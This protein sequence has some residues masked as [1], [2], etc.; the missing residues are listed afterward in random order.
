MLPL[1]VNGYHGGEGVICDPPAIEP[2]VKQ[3]VNLSPGT[4]RSR[5]CGRRAVPVS[6]QALIGCRH[7]RGAVR[8]SKWRHELPGPPE[9]STLIRTLYRTLY[10]TFRKPLFAINELGNRHGCSICGWTGFFFAPFGNTAR[11]LGS[12]PRCGS[13]ERHRLFHRLVAGSLGENLTV[14][15]VAPEKMV[16][17]LLKP[18]IGE[19]LSIDLM[20]PAMR[21]M[22]LTALDLPDA[23]FDLIF[24][25]HVLE[26]IPED[27]RAIAEM[28]RVLK[29]GGTAL[30][31]VPIRGESTYED[32]T[33]VSEEART[34][35]FLQPDHV[36]I[37]GLDIIERL[38]EP[39]FD[40]KVRSIREIDEKDVRREKLGYMFANEIFV[41]GR[42]PMAGDAS[43]VTF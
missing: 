2:R 41:C 25:S 22:D 7:H 42:P 23:S 29:P 17:G 40:V 33:I 35:A 13:L 31:L 5:R 38:Q 8:P 32:E 16:H 30:V 11:R 6:P 27:R 19:Y 9:I 21:Q 36:R 39:G 37:Y 34:K 18:H 20:E 12:C 3:R 28:F 43:D 1:S 10:R 15:H 24:C 4:T 26:H 14:L